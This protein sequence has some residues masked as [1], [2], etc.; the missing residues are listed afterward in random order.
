[1]DDD[2]FRIE[3]AYLPLISRKRDENSSPKY[4]EGRLSNEPEFFC[5][6]IRLA[7]KS[8]KGL[9][10]VE[11]SDS[12]K[13]IALNAYKLLDEWKRIPGSQEDGTFEPSYFDNWT[14]NVIEMTKESGHLHPALRVLGKNLINSP[15]GDDKLW[16]HTTIAEFLNRRELDSVRDAFRMAVYNSRGVH[17]IDP[18]AKPELKLSEVYQSKS[19]ALEL[20]GYQRIARTLREVSEGYAMEA[21]GI[22]RRESQLPINEI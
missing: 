21:E 1:M 9:S 7:Y 16:I 2:R 22:I 4:L 8:D 12:Q 13:N 10:E 19:E 15:E 18:E 17:F 14:N 6:I 3:W 20:L 11:L 5:E